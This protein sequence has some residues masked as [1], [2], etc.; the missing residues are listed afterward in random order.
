[1]FSKNRGL[2]IW[3]ALAI[4]IRIFSLFPHAVEKYY[5]N[6]L[7]P[8]IGQLQRLIFG[9]IPVS[10]GDLIYAAAFIY[11]LTAVYRLIKTIR[12][13]KFNRQFFFL[14]T[15][16]WITIILAIYVLFNFLWGL[17]YNRMGIASQLQ[18]EPRKYSKEELVTVVQLIINK[19]NTLEE[20]SHATLPELKKKRLLFENAISAFSTLSKEDGSFTYSF[21]AVKPSLY[22]Y[23]GNYLGF[24]GYYNPFT[25]EAQV[26]T[27]VPLFL[28]PFTTCHEIGHQ[29]GYAKESEANFVSFLSNRVSANPA[30]RYSLY[31]DLYGYAR[32][33]IF[34]ADTALLRSFDQQLLP[35]V[36]S[37]Y[38]TLKKFIDNHANPVEVVID[39]LYGQYL[40]ANE[41][42]SG[43]LSYNE[44]IGWLIAYYRK[45]GM[46]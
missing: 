3:S 22:S 31:F 6:G 33:Y 24:T 35:A 19:L 15:R 10:I 25:G 42:P 40:R 37:D 7:Y 2:I 8:V 30:F 18:I 46:M 23:L 32:R 44:V 38:R 43:R 39:K 36:R 17:N 5:S 9:W 12:H 14:K 21:P 13:K 1:M 4:A 27:T 20:A 28:Q 29:L 16:K 11:L 41:Q 26:N 34:M 45:Y